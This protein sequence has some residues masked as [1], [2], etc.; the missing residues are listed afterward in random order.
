MK[1]SVSFYYDHPLIFLLFYSKNIVPDTNA[2]ILRPRPFAFHLHSVRLRSTVVRWRFILCPV[3]LRAFKTEAA[4]RK[5]ITKG[6]NADG[7]RTQK[8]RVPVKNDIF[9]VLFR[10]KNSVLILYF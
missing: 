10:K 2:F 1:L 3:P 9:T 5:W 6:R 7:T 8:E 4:E